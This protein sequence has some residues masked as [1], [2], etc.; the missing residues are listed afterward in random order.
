MTSICL[1]M[2]VHNEARYLPRVWENLKDRISAA[3]IL[4]DP[5]ND[6]D[7]MEV[8]KQLFGH[9]PGRIAERP[10]PGTASQARN[11]IIDEARQYADYVLWLDPDSPLEGQIPDDLTEP[12]YWIRTDE[13]GSSWWIEHL[14][15]SDTRATWVGRVHEYLETDAPVLRLEGPVVLRAGSGG[16]AERMLALD[17][18]LLL[19]DIQD[20]PTNPRWPFYLAQT[21]KDTGQ[22]DKAIEWYARRAAMNGYMEE[23]Y[24]SLYQVGKLNMGRNNAE[25]E[26]WLLRAFAYRPTR[27]EALRQLVW[28][29]LCSNEPVLAWMLQANYQTMPPT[30]DTLFVEVK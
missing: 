29:Y 14:I 8:A 13:A 5:P 15:R 3:V 18:P 26:R 20:D 12:A 2:M 9:L 6:D 25:A 16:G 7:T 23:V 10:W 4:S 22:I 19:E 11:E 30:T 21:Y 1:A 17:I 27:H 24:F 28:F